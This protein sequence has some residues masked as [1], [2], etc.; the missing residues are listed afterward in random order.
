MQHSLKLRQ[1]K[2][3]QEILFAL[4]EASFPFAFF[5]MTTFEDTV[6]GVLAAMTTPINNKEFTG[7]CN[8]KKSNTRQNTKNGIIIRL[9]I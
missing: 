5:V 6:V 7:I 8:L 3:E 4:P 2:N 9:I 1:K